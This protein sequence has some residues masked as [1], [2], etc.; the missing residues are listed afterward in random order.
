LHDKI[1]FPHILFFP[2]M[3]RAELRR[4]QPPA[5]VY[6][7]PDGWFLKFELAGVRRE[8]LNLTV[9]GQTLMLQ[10]TRRDERPR[11][12]SGYCCYLEITYSRFERVLELPGLSEDAE[13]SASYRDGMLLVEIRTEGRHER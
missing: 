11:L 12:G 10:G 3:P 6:R 4:W 8:D 2:A 13:I 9:R 7:T 5:D 1:C